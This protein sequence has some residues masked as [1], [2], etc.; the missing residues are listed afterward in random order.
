MIAETFQGI[1]QPGSD[2]VALFKSHGKGARVVLPAL[3]MQSA[4]G[5]S[6]HLTIEF[7]APLPQTPNPRSYRPVA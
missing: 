2:T 6:I 1:V 4:L 3:E 5:R 7:D